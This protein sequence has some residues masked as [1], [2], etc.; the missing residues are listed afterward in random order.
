MM[1]TFLKRYAVLFCLLALLIVAALALSMSAAAAEQEEFYAVNVSMSGSVSLNFFYTSLGDADSVMIIETAP[2]GT[3][4][5]RGAVDVADIPTDSDGRFVI[6]AKLAAAEMTNYITVYTQKNGEKL[7]QAR[8]YSVRDYAEMVLARE[9]YK[10]YH[11]IMKA[12]LN[13]GAMAQTHFGVNT[14][15]LANSE[16][17]RS[18]TNPVNAVTDIDCPNPSWVDGTTLKH[19]SY[20]AVL[21]SSTAFKI[22]FT[23]SGSSSLSATVERDGLEAQSTS[24]FHDAE[25]DR[26]YVRI[27]NIAASLYDKQY[28]VKVTDGSDNLSITASVLNYVDSVLSSDATTDTQKNAV[29]AMYN[30]YVWMTKSAPAVTECSHGYIHSESANGDTATAYICSVCGNLIKTV[31]DRVELFKSPYDIQKV[32]TSGWNQTAE[33]MTDEDGTVFARVHGGSNIADKYNSLYVYSD[34]KATGRFFV[35]KYRIRE[36]N[37]TAQSV[38]NSWAVSS[39]SR[40][41]NGNYAYNHFSIKLHQ[42]NQWYVAVVD[43]D[44]VTNDAT[45]FIPD[46]NGHYYTDMIWVRPLSANGQGTVEDYM[47]IA[48][49]AM[50]DS[51]LDIPVLVDEETYEKHTGG[52]TYGV[53]STQ[54]GE[55]SEHKAIETVNGKGYS[56]VCSICEKVVSEVDIPESVERFFPSSEIYNGATTYYQ[57]N[58]LQYGKGAG[59]VIYEDGVVF[60]RSFGYGSTAQMIW[61]RAEADGIDSP[62]S[63]QFIIPVGRADHLVMKI[64]TNNTA[65]HMQVAVSTS[66]SDGYSTVQIPLSA[67]TQDEWSTI[68]VDLATVLP[69]RYVASDGEYM[70]DFFMLHFNSFA[71]TTNVDIAYLA[72]V[73]DDWADIAALT[74]VESVIKVSDASG[75]YTTVDAATGMCR[76]SCNI[77]ESV[78]TDTDGNRI[79]TYKCSVCGDVKVS[80]SYD[81]SINWVSKLN[82]M[83]Y[84]TNGAATLTKLQFD[85]ENGVVY[86]R[87]AATSHTHWNI[88]GKTGAGCTTSEKY[89][90][91]NYVVF[92]YRIVSGTANL[93]LLVATSTAYKSDVSSRTGIGTQGSAN[94]PSEWTVGVVKIPDSTTDLFEQNTEAYLYAMFYPKG[95]ISMD[96][97]YFAFVDTLDE[98]ALL[99]DD[100]EP[101]TYYG[102]SFTNTG[103]ILAADGNCYE[104][105]VGSLATMSTRQDDAGNTVYYYS[106]SACGTVV[107][108]RAV[109]A[110]T[111][112]M[113]GYDWANGATTYYNA[114][115][116]SAIYDSDED[117]AFGR[118]NGNL[119]IL[120]HR[121]QADCKTGTISTQKTT[122]DVGDARFFVMRMRSS[123]TARTLELC[124]STTGKQGPVNDAGEVTAAGYKDVDIPVSASK[125]GEWT[126]YVIDLETLLSA[127]HIKDTETG[128]YVVDTFY[129]NMNS[130]SANHDVEYMAFVEGGWAELDTLIDDE[131]AIL[132]TSTSGG[133]SKVAVK[134]GGCVSCEYVESGSAGAYVYTCSVCGKVADFD[135][136]RYYPSS[137]VAG[138]ST[139]PFQLTTSS[140]YDSDALL[141]FVRF[142]GQGKTG[143]LIYNRYPIHYSGSGASQTTT[144]YKFGTSFNIGSGDKYL[145]VKY[146]TNSTSR[147]H[148][149]RIGTLNANTVAK[150][151]DGY[152]TGSQN[153]FDINIPLSKLSADEWTLL[154]FDLAKLGGSKWVSDANGDYIIETMMF[155]GTVSAS[156]NFDIAYM[157]YTDSLDDIA[158]LSGEDQALYVYSSGVG[159]MINLDGTCAE[160]GC[161]IDDSVADGIYKSYCMFCGTVYEQK[162]ISSVNKFIGAEQMSAYNPLYLTHTFCTEYDAEQ[163]VYETFVRHTYSN[164]N[165]Q[166]VSLGNEGQ[167]FLFGSYVSASPNYEIADTGR[168]LVMRMRTFNAL[169]LILEARTG[170]GTKTSVTRTLGLNDGWENVIIDLSQYAN[171]E[172]DATDTTFTVRFR[173]LRGSSSDPLQTIDISYA[174]IVDSLDEAAALIGGGETEL[175]EKWSAAPVTYIDNGTDCSSG[176]L[177]HIPSSTDCTEVAICTEC[178]VTLREAGEHDYSIKNNNEAYL[179]TRPTSDAPASYYYTCRCGAVSNKT[180]TIGKT[181]SEMT[182]LDKT[183]RYKDI[184]ANITNGESFLYFTDPHFVQAREQATFNREYEFFIDIMGEHYKDTGASFV[185]CG[186]DWLTNSNTRENA[187]M[188]LRDIDRRMQIAFGNKFYL[189]VG[190]HDYNYQYQSSSGNGQSPYW[191]TDEEINDAWYTDERYGGKSYYS[192][193][194]ENTRFYV[195]NSGIDWNHS[196]INEFD[197]EQIEW[198]LGELLRRDDEHIALA[199]HIL[200]NSGVLAATDKILEF[201]DV[202]NNRGTVIYNGRLYDFSEKT[203]R[204][205]F[206]IAGHSH[207]DEVAYYHNIPCILVL[208]EGRSLVYPEFDMVAVD[209]DARVLYTVRAGIDSVTKLKNYDR[210]VA[211]DYVEE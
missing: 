64:R 118:E 83:N 68:V 28:T 42:D 85:S 133:Y 147:S 202:Y 173:F 30:H 180:F 75:A 107:Y 152:Y 26:Y 50:C 43:L 23:Y 54:T 150:G 110:G 76:G 37:P 185:L 71:T 67:T 157:A 59:S 176:V 210:V 162:D 32:Y 8:T 165:S 18:S 102:T 126:T 117:I 135:T 194:G 19:T 77:S 137:K 192:F 5:S 48:Y 140:G 78:S 155:T 90:S 193:M 144:N 151:E 168:Y 134:D 88:M 65:Q 12:M 17:Y 136:D 80:E 25:N 129:F 149:L 154:V 183:D 14:E 198:F 116:G 178:G 79:Y 131:T 156:Q 46:S 171:Y 93:Q 130:T 127:Y 181:L 87:Y 190:N 191:L 166:G 74:G 114:G 146:R 111:T 132:I 160:G 141:S 27:N 92:K 57:I 206:L 195:F 209:Y 120:W 35:I 81:A 100:G 123:N 128:T 86:N 13:Y 204:V 98:V 20:E 33:V 44:Q 22:Y 94:H 199:P 16:L 142:T 119:Q 104:H 186:G 105:T 158:T 115:A 184:V 4:I 197:A 40:D 203:G 15:S 49:I 10:E 56:Y 122:R 97:A 145:A 125:A 39:K 61:N 188:N 96:I 174:A 205:E 60:T 91:G 45:G 121:A 101:Y 103:S 3:E 112:L 148:I 170:D 139:N 161:I 41:D 113:N 143:Q 106:C 172:V 164:A 200:Y 177:G 2:D 34:G 72:I 62:A 182:S 9:S 207:R 179:C 175:Y 163:G 169:K 69:T 187:I 208:N 201:S 6:S 189:V 7:G 53:V 159:N 84:Y 82:A 167:F 11:D 109:P 58:G 95:K 211:L 63:E 29:R 51:L 138:S 66:A 31:A 24:V 99:L 52:N 70:I 38:L 1:K 124:Y 47:D 153:Y 73:E 36:D 21:E 196:T 55:C 89:Q 108:E